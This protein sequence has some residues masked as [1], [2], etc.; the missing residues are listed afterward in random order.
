MPMSV[1]DVERRRQPRIEFVRPCKVYDARSRRYIAG[2]TWNVSHEGV[3][4]ELHGPVPLVPGDELHVGVA[5]RRREAVLCRREMLA[6]RVVRAAM[7]ADDRTVVALR[8]RQPLL[9]SPAPPSPP[10][11]TWLPLEP[12]LAA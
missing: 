5:A 2:R 11:P 4:V 10:K 12:R 6:G 9:V 7:T 3:L 8:L 1:D